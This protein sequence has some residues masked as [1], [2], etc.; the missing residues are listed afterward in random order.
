MSA[1]LT[2]LIVI[3]CILLALVVLVQNPKGGGLAAGFSGAQ[4]LGGVQRTTDFLEKST[5]GLVIA[6]MVLSIASVSLTDKTT[7]GIAPDSDGALEQS[8]ESAPSS[9]P[10]APVGGGSDA[11]DLFDEE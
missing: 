5:W 6:L 7:P 11:T 2:I 8:I 3:V 10:V 4:Q 1:L 9:Q